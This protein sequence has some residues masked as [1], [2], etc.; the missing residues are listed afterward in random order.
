MMFSEGSRTLRVLELLIEALDS[1]LVRLG[2]KMVLFCQEINLNAIVFR[3]F[4]NRGNAPV[5]VFWVGNGCAFFLPL[6]RD[7][8]LGLRAVII[9]GF[10]R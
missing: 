9:F 2:K 10:C 5:R 3:N 6:N 8:F 4:R 7:L 1:L